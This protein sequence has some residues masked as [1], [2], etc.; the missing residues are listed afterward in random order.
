ME[1]A[2]LIFVC[3]GDEASYRAHAY[4]TIIIHVPVHKATLSFAVW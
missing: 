2:S 4:R 3:A 1:S